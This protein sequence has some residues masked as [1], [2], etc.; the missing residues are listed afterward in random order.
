MMTDAEDEGVVMTLVGRP[1]SGATVVEFEGTGEMEGDDAIEAADLQA[2][3]LT[4]TTAAASASNGDGTRWSS[5][6]PGL[7][8]AARPQPALPFL[9]LRC[10]TTVSESMPGSLTRSLPPVAPAIPSG[11]ERLVVGDSSTCASARRSF[12]RSSLSRLVCF[13][14]SK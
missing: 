13:F 4:F 5:R 2:G 14:A 10:E 7:V 1:S 9:D 12:L 3:S 6:A 11:A 8:A